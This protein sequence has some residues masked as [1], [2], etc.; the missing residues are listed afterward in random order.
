MKNITIMFNI[1]IS[2]NRQQK[3]TMELRVLPVLPEFR[4]PAVMAERRRQSV[5]YLSTVMYC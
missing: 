1:L 2:S 3:V 4:E 5:Y